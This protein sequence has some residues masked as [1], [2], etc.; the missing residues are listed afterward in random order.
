MM[1]PFKEGGSFEPPVPLHRGMMMAN[2]RHDAITESR[3]TRFGVVPDEKKC[4][5]RL[6]EVSIVEYKSVTHLFL[7]I[8]PAEEVIPFALPFM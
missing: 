2:A 8:L 5:T 1:E 4:F 6:P 7:T 3:N